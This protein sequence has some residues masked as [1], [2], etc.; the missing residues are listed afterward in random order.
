[1]DG[2]C[3]LLLQQGKSKLDYAKPSCKI[4]AHAIII[5]QNF[6]VLETRILT[7]SSTG[8]AFLKSS[9]ASSFKM[10]IVS[11]TAASVVHALDVD[12]DVVT[13][14]SLLRALVVHLDSENLQGEDTH[15]V[16]RGLGLEDA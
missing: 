5:V 14:L 3:R 2:G 11:W 7:L 6:D 4:Q 13:R 8:K 9:S 16:G 15:R 12:A 10:L 1:V